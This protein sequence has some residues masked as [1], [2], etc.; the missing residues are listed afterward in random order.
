MRWVVVSDETD[1]GVSRA[2]LHGSNSE[3][4]DALDSTFWAAPKITASM[5][6]VVPKAATM[7]EIASPARM[8]PKKAAP[9]ASSTAGVM[10]ADGPQPHLLRAKRPKNMAHRV[11][12]PVMEE[13]WPMKAE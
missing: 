10:R 6:G 9:V 12:T 1:A 7:G 3:Y 4:L 8:K 2:S 13:N 11:T 5:S